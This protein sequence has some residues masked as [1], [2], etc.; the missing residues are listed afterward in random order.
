[1]TSPKQTRISPLSAAS[2]KVPAAIRKNLIG[3]TYGKL[4]VIAFGGYRGTAIL[5]RCRCE[6][7]RTDDYYRAN[8]RSGN[9]RQC[10][11]CGQQQFVESSR[12]HGMCGTPTYRTWERVIRTGEVCK[13]WKSFENFFKD[14]GKRPTVNHFLVRKDSAS[15]WR[16]ENADWLHKTKARTRPGRGKLI[17]YKGRAQTLTEWAREIGISTTSLRRR[18]SAGWTRKE[19]FETP[20]QR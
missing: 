6:C 20:P 15:T 10:L 8:L 9:S 4:T 16:P 7:G 19:V 11:K 12:A 3:E 17:R 14:M 1:M 18:M 5:W 13:R 2:R